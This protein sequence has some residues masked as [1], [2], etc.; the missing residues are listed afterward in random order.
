MIDLPFQRQALADFLRTRRARLSPAAVGLPTGGRRRTSGLRREEV[1]SLANVGISWYT[2][3]EQGRDVHPSEGILNSLAEVLQLT[4]DEREHLFAL[5][6]YSVTVPI[7]EIVS[8][9]LQQILHSLE[10][11]PAYIMG[12]SWNYLAWN[13]TAA[14]LFEI[15]QNDP[16]Y[17]DNLLWQLFMNPDKRDFYV[18]WDAVAQNVVAEFRAEVAK[19]QCQPQIRQLIADL[20][21][22]SPD[23]NRMWQQHNVQRTVIRRKEIQHKWAGRLSFDH[24]PL[25]LAEHPTLKLIVYTPTP[26]SVQKLQLIKR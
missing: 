22:V 7:E 25:L 19:Y 11:G 23:F 10:P 20:Q 6:G 15:S 24:T 8:P 3:L 5:A 17:G 18:N 14:L 12:V 1:S 21:D 9:V 26:E 13:N 4:L 16:P 2:A